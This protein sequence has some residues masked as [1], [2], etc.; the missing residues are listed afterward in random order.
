MKSSITS[1][2]LVRQFGDCLAR[3]KF[4]GEVFVVTKNDEQVAELR[5]LGGAAGGSWREVREALRLLPFDPDFS[6]DL[7]MV[8]DLDRVAEDPWR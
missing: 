6:K 8:N 7:K 2:E 1:T 4:R 3:V 5:P